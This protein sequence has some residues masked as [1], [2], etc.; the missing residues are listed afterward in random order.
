M[1]DDHAPALVALAPHM[2]DEALAAADAMA[3]ETERAR[4]LAV[5]APRVAEPGRA[6]AIERALAAARA[7]ED[8]EERCEMLTALAGHDPAVAGEALAAARLIEDEEDARGHA[9]ALA[10]VLDGEETF[11]ALRFALAAAAAI[12]LGNYREA[13]LSELE[14]RLPDALLPEAVSAALATFE[15]GEREQLLAMVDEPRGAADEDE[16]EG[17]PAPPLPAGERAAALAAASAIEDAGDRSKA[18]AKLCERSPAEERPR[19]LTEALARVLDDAGS[20]LDSRGLANV[21]GRLA[22]QLPE[23]LL[24]HAFAIASRIPRGRMRRRALDSLAVTAPAVSPPILHECFDI[25][26]RASV[27]RLDVPRFVRPLLPI[28]DRLGQLDRGGVP[29]RPS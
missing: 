17:E 29:W 14:P 9:D 15:T 19:E 18:L 25:A 3:D 20:T 8:P 10:P 26:L 23:A 1:R 22:P 7:L 5:I 12:E 27:E 28:V 2:P 13:A 16:D 4:A 11:E 24:P 21:V 6:A